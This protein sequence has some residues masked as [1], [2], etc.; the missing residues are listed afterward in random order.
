MKHIIPAVL[1]ASASLTADAQ[2][3]LKAGI[4][5]TNLNTKVRPADDFYQYAC[6]GWMTKNPLPAAYSRFG[7]FDLLAKDNNER[8]NTIL[9]DLLKKTYAKGTTEQKLSDLYKLAMD[10][11]RRNKEGVQPAMPLI[12][13]MEKAKTVQDLRAVQ[14]KYAAFGYGQP[15]HGGF[16]ADEKNAKMNIFSISQ[17]G[18]T[19]GLKEYYLDKDK[20]TTAIREAYK[21]HVVRMF[22]L[23]GFSESSAMKKRDA[24]M[25]I[26]TALAQASKSRT[27]LRDVEANYNKMTLV[28]FEEKYPNISLKALLNAEGVSTEYFQEMIVGQPKFLETADKIVADMTADELRAYMEWDAILSAANYLSDD[29]VAANFDFFGKTMTGQG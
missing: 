25:K 18:L 4:D 28:Q 13:E 6:G 27:E 10:S 23:F 3:Q 21:K 20:A 9:S 7:S 15:F 11:V 26:E 14:L 24:I 2:T 29:V 8:I 16:G 5:I 12:Y 19:L 17:G 1:F 22:K